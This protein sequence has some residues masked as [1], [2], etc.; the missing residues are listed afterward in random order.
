MEA[1]RLW[2]EQRRRENMEGMFKASALALPLPP[3]LPDA[4]RV[5]QAVRS[6]VALLRFAPGD[7][8]DPQR[9]AREVAS[10][11]EAG[12]SAFGVCGDIE[13]FDD[14]YQH[15][16]HIAQVTHLPVVCHELVLDPLQI[17]L[18]RAHG[19]AAV[20]L[21]REPH[22]ERE[23]R[24][25]LRAAHEVSLDVV[26]MAFTPADVEFF[27]STRRP[28]HDAL[29]I[30]CITAACPEGVQEARRS[31]QL[32]RMAHAMPHD[33]L[34]MALLDCAAEVSADSLE[35]AGFESFWLPVPWGDP[36]AVEKVRRVA[37]GHNVA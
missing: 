35:D 19:A 13:P 2:A 21:Q 29:G 6:V 8:P 22:G 28:G 5:P 7:S 14:V 1:K 18:A 4:L 30:R 17:V 31:A 24:Q 25:L 26:A 32:E 9:M 16:L 12:A 23:F 20:C 3:A 15:L 33:V 27:S 36:D 34:P 10:L 11:V 37:A